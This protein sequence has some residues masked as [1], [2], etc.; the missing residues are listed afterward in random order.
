MFAELILLRLDAAVRALK[1]AAPS[2][3][4]PVVPIV[5]GTI[6]HWSRARA[7]RSSSRIVR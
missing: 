6:L 4:S 1:E 7:L 2:A 5:P 3:T